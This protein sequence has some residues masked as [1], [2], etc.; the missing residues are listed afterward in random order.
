M[1]TTM[2][3]V[4]AGVALAVAGA[5]A[6]APASAGC[7][8]FSAPSGPPAWQTGTGQAR[9]IATSFMQVS[10]TGDEAPI[11]GLWKFKFMAKGNV[12]PTAPPDGAVIDAGYVTWHADGTELMNSGRAPITGSFCMGVWKQATHNSFKLNHYALAWDPSGTVM[13]GPANITETVWVNAAA[14]VYSG[15]FHLVQYATDEKTVLADIKGTVSATRI[16]VN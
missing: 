2:G 5:L 16:T 13:V 9:L 7:S 3:S 1:K 12:G 11:V 6:A 14:S 15:F 4:A 8:N 10:D